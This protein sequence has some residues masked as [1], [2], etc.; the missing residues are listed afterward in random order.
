MFDDNLTFGISTI[1]RDIK[2][3]KCKKE[4]KG[5]RKKLRE[6][7]SYPQTM[8]EKWGKLRWK[9]KNREEERKEEGKEGR[10]GRSRVTGNQSEEKGDG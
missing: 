5:E 9:K 3:R 10:R 7:F 1:V 4:K 6:F 8:N 2:K